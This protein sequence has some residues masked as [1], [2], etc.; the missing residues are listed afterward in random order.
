MWTEI[1]R[2]KYEREGL[3]YAS[4]LTDRE[5]EMIAPF[6]PPAKAVGRPRTTDPR[7]AVNAILYLLG[8]GC[9]WRMLPREFPPRSTVQHYFY[10]WRDDATRRRRIQTGARSV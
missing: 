7:E 10:A 5:W 4:D 6:L 3:R 1:T 2:P 8:S 9:P